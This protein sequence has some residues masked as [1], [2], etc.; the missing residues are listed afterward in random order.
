MTTDYY[1]PRNAEDQLR[2]LVA[3]KLSAGEIAKIMRVTRN[4]V[5]GKCDR[6]GLQLVGSR[7]K[8]L[9]R[10][11]PRRMVGDARHATPDRAAPRPP[12]PPRR[13]TWEGLTPPD[14]HA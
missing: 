1:W 10:K 14:S 5:I 2:L 7:V 9:E 13:F 11:R 3:E 8:A 6:L 12:T 4:A